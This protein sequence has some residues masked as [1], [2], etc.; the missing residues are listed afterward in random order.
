MSFNI[1]M[2]MIIIINLIKANNLFRVNFKRRR[3]K[4]QSTEIQSG[5]I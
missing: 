2:M 5:F 1:I 3:S 4:E